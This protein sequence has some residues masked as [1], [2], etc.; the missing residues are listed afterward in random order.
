MRIAIAT[1]VAVI[2]LSATANGQS[3]GIDAVSLR[4]GVRAGILAPETGSKYEPITFP[5]VG[6][7]SQR[8]SL[9]PSLASSSPAWQRINKMDPS[10]GNHRHVWRD[11]GIG[12]AVG[13]VAAPLSE[14]RLT[15]A[16]ER[17]TA[18]SERWP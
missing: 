18:N 17:K 13:A 2:V 9:R 8:Y 5:S 7:S 1:A 3:A 12:F 6:S 11:A 15:V 16:A 4:A 10:T 14:P